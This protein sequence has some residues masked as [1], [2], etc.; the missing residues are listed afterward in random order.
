MQ[1]DPQEESEPQQKERSWGWASFLTQ[2]EEQV[3]LVLTLVIGAVVG[4]LVVAFILL[5]QHFS[6]RIYPV[7]E[8]AAWRRLLIPVAGSLAMGYL[9]FR[10]FP[11]ARGSG[12]PQTKA[13]LYAR[14][15]RISLSTVFGKF[16]CTSATL[17]SGIPLGRE[18][19]SVQVGAGIAS[20]LGRKL[21]LRPEKIKA[22]IPVGA[23]AA[24]AAAFNTPLAAVLFALEE[25]VGD[26]HAPVLGSVV[27]ASATSWA[28]LRMLLGNDPLFKVPEYQLVHPV[29]LV[30]YAILGIAGG[31]VSAAFSRLLLWLRKRFLQFSRKTVWF[32]PVAGG[33]V[34]G[35]MG[36]FVPQILG[37]GYLHVGEALNGELALKIMILLLVLKFFAVVAS[38]SSGNAGGIFGPSLFLGAMLGG[39]IGT[40]A[41]MALPGYVGRPGAYALVGM[42]TAFAG[43]VRAPMTSVVMIFEITR[44]YAVI[45]PLMISNLLSFFIAARLQRKPIYEELARQDGIHL[46]GEEMSTGAGQIRVAAIL[47]PESN[48]LAA[49]LSVAEA[50]E[51]MRT[52]KIRTGLIKS[53]RGVEGVVNLETLK[54][55][56][57]KTPSQKLTDIL[58]GEDFPHVHRDHTLAQALDRMGTARMD[59]LP[60]VSRANVRMLEGIVTLRDV[61]DRYGV[62][63]SE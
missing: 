44:D 59:L 52:T 56:M 40:C 62:S 17:A 5:T 22:L 20:F 63:A 54:S 27:L 26:L 34:V 61:L 47:R 41:H 23:A 31:L 36:W 14:E 49:E 10:F 24:V 21:G 42:G 33:L 15:G 51:R 57:E 3:F 30:A 16:F 4:A 46:P 37:V 53:G 2:R 45:V 38:Y 12:V 8:G 60:V 28:V 48:S 11:D 1:K 13:A 50:L 35:I 6:A 19:P 7:H 43:I 58:Q 39:I 25:V 9:L 29:E 32:Q 18:G 55:A